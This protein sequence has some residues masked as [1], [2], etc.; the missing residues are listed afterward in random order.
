MLLAQGAIV[1]FRRSIILQV[2]PSGFVGETIIPF[3]DIP[4]NLTQ[5]SELD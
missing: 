1:D 5:T 2:L 4:D 3:F